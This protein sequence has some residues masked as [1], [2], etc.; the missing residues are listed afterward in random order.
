MSLVNTAGQLWISVFT[1]K[2]YIL[3][4]VRPWPLISKYCHTPVQFLRQ[5]KMIL[6]NFCT[7]SKLSVHPLN[8]RDI[9]MIRVN[10]LYNRYKCRTKITNQ[11]N[12]V[13]LQMLHKDDDINFWMLL[14]SVCFSSS[15]WRTVHNSTYTCIGDLVSTNYQRTVSS[16]V[17]TC[18]CTVYG[19]IKRRIFSFVTSLFLFTMMVVYKSRLCNSDRFLSKKTIC[20]TY[21]QFLTKFLQWELADILIFRLLLLGKVV[22]ISSSVYRVG[23]AFLS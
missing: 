10:E 20:E 4:L 23:W 7:V 17:A 12:I 5:T 14:V 15:G 21:L 22:V 3:D 2:Y 13:T 19:K 9:T 6:R 1:W 18:Q 8:Y 16:S 11:F